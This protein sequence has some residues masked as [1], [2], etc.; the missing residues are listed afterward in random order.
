[1][2]NA[3]S[4]GIQRLVDAMSQQDADQ[5][6]GKEPTTEELAQRLRDRKGN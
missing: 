5:E 4:D 1:M 2:R 6:E 3:S